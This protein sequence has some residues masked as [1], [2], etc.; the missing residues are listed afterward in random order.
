MDFG[1][2][3]ECQF[4]QKFVNLTVNKS[5]K[6]NVPSCCCSCEFRSVKSKKIHVN[7]VQNQ[8]W[9][10]KCHN[11][12]KKKCR[13]NTQQRIKPDGTQNSFYVKYIKR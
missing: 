13:K 12:C 5:A 3:M 7:Y 11:F 6:Y 4:C 8:N 1:K 2:M 9:E 10:T